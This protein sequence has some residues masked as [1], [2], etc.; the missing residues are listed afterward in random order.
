V[1]T[2]LCSF[3]APWSDPDRC[4]IRWLPPARPVPGVGLEPGRGGCARCVLDRRGPQQVNW[5]LG[6]RPQHHLSPVSELRSGPARLT[7]RSSAAAGGPGQGRQTGTRRR[8][9]SRWSVKPPAQ[10]TLVRTQHLPPPAETQF[11]RRIRR[12]VHRPSFR[13]SALTVTSGTPVSVAVY[14]RMTDGRPALLRRPAG[15]TARV[16]ASGWHHERRGWLWASWSNRARWMTSSSRIMDGFRYDLHQLN[17]R[18][19]AA[20]DGCR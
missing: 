9:A 13:G 17:M 8:G 10:P 20:S 11:D 15:P 5:R 1:W 12:S 6:S 14:G 3:C 16:V 18:R 19:S 4:E 7:V 2:S